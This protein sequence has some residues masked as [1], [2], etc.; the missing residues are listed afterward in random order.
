MCSIS[1]RVHPAVAFTQ[2]V[3]KVKRCSVVFVHLC[4][5]EL[6][7]TTMGWLYVGS[8]RHGNFDG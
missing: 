5:G 7:N 4:R 3:M 1:V 6:K 8:F 2:L